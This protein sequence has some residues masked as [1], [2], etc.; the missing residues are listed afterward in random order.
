MIGDA[1]RLR[2]Q[3]FWR[4]LARIRT[5]TVVADLIASPMWQ[6]E[7][8]VLIADAGKLTR[9]VRHLMRDENLALALDTATHGHHVRG[10]HR[11]A[12]SLEHLWPGLCH[13]VGGLAVAVP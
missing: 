2:A 12:E 7:R 6:G 4:Q 11:A 1:R 9:K 8:Q 3:A 13:V 10:H 5:G